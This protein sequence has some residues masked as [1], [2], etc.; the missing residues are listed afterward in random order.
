MFKLEYLKRVITETKLYE[1][2]H[3]HLLAFAYPMPDFS[4]NWKSKPI[5]YDLVLK[6]DTLYFVNFDESNN[7]YLE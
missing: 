7:P 4:D 5:R 2:K 1:T 3:W 6:P